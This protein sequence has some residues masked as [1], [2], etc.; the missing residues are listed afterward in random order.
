MASPQR[1][2]PAEAD[3]SAELHAEPRPSVP[4]KP[5]VSNRRRYYA[6]VIVGLILGFWY[7]GFG[8][9]NSGGWIWGNGNRNATVR[10]AEDGDVSGPGVVILEV[11]NKQDYIGQSFQVRN[12]AVDHW[13]GN[14]AVWI[15]S[16]H[17]YLPILLILPSASPLAPAVTS[18]ASSGSPE[19][20]PSGRVQRLDVTG[21]IM[22]AP[23][24]AQAQQQWNLSDDDVD[25]LEGEGVYI[26]AST[27]RP[28]KH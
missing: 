17:S 2:F 20:G 13:S 18:A 14:R 25:Q 23:P 6:W 21:S 16:R 7:V 22:K 1:K 28:A 15:G 3:R 5:P 26:Q 12:V 9:G 4:P 24:T 27:V 10:V 8:W 19:T 11:A